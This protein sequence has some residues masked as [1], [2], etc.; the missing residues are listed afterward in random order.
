MENENDFVSLPIKRTSPCAISELTID[1]ARDLAFALGSFDSCEL[2]ECLR[3]EEGN[4]QIF[5]AGDEIIVF[6]MGV[7]VSQQPV[8][9]IRYCERI[10]VLFD[11]QDIIMPFTFALR[12]SFP[13]VLHRLSLDFKQP[14]CLCIYEVAYEELKL[15][16][17][18]KKFLQDIRTWLSLTA[19]DKLHTNDQPLEPFI[20]ASSGR[21]ILPHDIKEEDK[22]HISMVSSKP[23]E[24]NLIAT[25]QQLNVEQQFYFKFLAGKAQDHG[26]IE[27]TPTNVFELHEFL[28]KAEIDLLAVL[29]T[30]LRGMAPD[31]KVLKSHLLLLVQLPKKAK[32][33]HFVETDFYAF[34]MQDDIRSLGLALNV[35]SPGPDG[36]GHIFPYVA[37]DMEK[38]SLCRIGIL[39][40]YFQLSK[41]TRTLFSGEP[42]RQK[43][44]AITLVGAGALGS[45]L[46][47][48]LAKAGYGK[49]DVIDSDTLLPHN[50]IRHA[51]TSMQVG[52]PKAI[53]LSAEGNN[54][55]DDP[56]FAKGMWENIIRPVDPNVLNQALSQADII[57]DISASIVV[58]RIL[59]GR[60][61]VKARCI[62]IFLNPP[63]TDLVILAEDTD[64][65]YRLD[66][67]EFQYYRA[68]LRNE[69]LKEHL[70]RSDQIRYSNSCRD[71]TSRISQDLVALHAA[72]GSR[73]IK[74]L[75]PSAD[76]EICVYRS[77][78]EG[79][80]SRITVPV[81][82]Y[83][84]AKCGE[85]EVY[86]DEFL[87]RLMAA[88]RV[89]KLPNETGGI[90][91]GGYDFERKKV[92][93]MD[94]ILSPRDSEETPGSYIRGIH[95]VKEMLNEIDKDSGGQLMYAGEWHSHPEGCSLHMSDDDKVLF[96]QIEVE[97]NSIGF[98]A[99]MLIVGDNETFEIYM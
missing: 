58:E 95:G 17:R 82:N 29:Q 15:Q 90:L 54:V 73:K 89:E 91:I 77:D 50:T 27:E 31:K 45:Q 12:K 18:S 47:M 88:A 19:D 80:V 25:R 9:D 8:N 63:G 76:A 66:V 2:V 46:F 87:V 13:W 59:S 36:L 21:L 92:Y 84:T 94:A 4:D 35:W 5:K 67:L 28:L 86:I 38:I 97:M 96:K 65:V 42:T 71:V 26:I 60:Q 51:L 75:I 55:V 48:N 69:K 10:A 49:W 62:S 79:E 83:C 32:N 40:P 57:L 16:W 22:L 53:A 7:S 34:W 41:E 52:Y 81:A 61:E 99:L 72:I 37:P 78:E 20:F 44:I 14:A 93:L 68:L 23:G 30:W 74:T 85:W 39:T 64:R 3:I 24:I 1:K 98:P 6:D 33:R 43:D 11:Q 70:R 56:E